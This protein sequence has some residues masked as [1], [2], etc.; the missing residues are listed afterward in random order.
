MHT[1]ASPGKTRAAF[2]LIELLVVIAII[3]I[4]IALLVPAVQKVREAAA[5]TQ[6]TNNLK[7]MA[8]ALHGY[9]DANKK[10][11]VGIEADCS[12]NIY[13][14]PYLEQNQLFTQFTFGVNNFWANANTGNDNLLN[15]VFLTVFKCPSSPMQDMNGSSQNGDVNLQKSCY[16]GISGAIN[17]L[18]PGYTETRTEAGTPAT[19]TCCNGNIISGGGVLFPNSAVTMVQITDGTSNT[20]CLSEWASYLNKSTSPVDW[21]SPH[22][23]AMGNGTGGVSILP[24]P[25]WNGGGGDIRTFN[26]MTIRYSIN[27]INGWADDCTTGVCSNHGANAPLRSEHPG[28]VNIAMCD[29]TVRFLESNTS[30]DVLARLATRD[31]GQTV[32]LP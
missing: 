29:G 18:I 9:H 11:P 10:L 1:A 13:L 4:L 6:C 32:T 7:Q 26:V 30:I 28:G 22:G 5:R 8:L 24:P 2:T 25:N 23:F 14:L 3:A 16:V 20:M 12:F 27:Q 17:G 19:V 15:N 21:R 31:D